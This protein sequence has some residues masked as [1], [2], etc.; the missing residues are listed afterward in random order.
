MTPMCKTWH[1]VDH[2]IDAFAVRGDHEGQYVAEAL[3]DVRAHIAVRRGPVE[4]E[5]DMEIAIGVLPDCVAR[6]FR[7]R[8]RWCTFSAVSASFVDDPTSIRFCPSALTTTKPSTSTMATMIML[9]IGRII[10]RVKECREIRN[11]L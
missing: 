9:A 8:C 5:F 3:E 1:A 6:R 2:R 11:A 10:R 4:I 7:A